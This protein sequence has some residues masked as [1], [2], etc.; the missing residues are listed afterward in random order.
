MQG[1]IIKG[2]AGFY[3]VHNPEKGVYACKAKGIFRNENIKPLVGDMAEF[4]VTHEG[5]KE[6]SIDKILPPEKRS[7]TAG[8]GK[9]WIRP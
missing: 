5:D 2:I 4:H 1:K 9:M 8:C 3:Y 7:C 6:G